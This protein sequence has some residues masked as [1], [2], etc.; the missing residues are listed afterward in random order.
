MSLP[1]LI[2]RGFIGIAAML[3]IAYLF[4]SNRKAIDWRLVGVG[5]GLQ[6]VFAVL[7]LYTDAGEAVFR[8]IGNGF[9]QVLSFTYDGSEFIFGPMGSPGGG[10]SFGNIFAFQV[11]PTIVF[12]ASLM[13]VLYHL[14]LV[15]PLVRGMGRFMAWAMRISGAESLGTAANVF[16]GQT[17]APL[18]VEPYVKSMTRS[19]LMTL[20]TGGMS[21]IAGGVL[22][23][24]ITF[25]G[26]DDPAARAQFAGHLLS[27]SIMSAPAAIVMAKILVPETEE[28]PTYGD[29]EMQVEKEESNVIEAAANGASEGLRLALNVGA[30]LLA[31]IALI[32][33]INYLL[34]VLG[35]PVTFGTEWYDLNALVERVTDGQFT[36]LS[37]EAIFGFV[38]APLA[39]AMGVESADVLRFG[40]LLGEKVAVNEFVAFASLG[41][42]EGVLSERSIIIGTYALCGFANFSSIAIQIGG[43]GGI[44]PSRRSEIAE[45]GLRAVLAGALASW[46]TASIAGML[47]G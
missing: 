42:L 13:G 2:L 40:T 37:L 18:V 24:Y 29:V 11:L 7:V 14:G 25:L 34:G 47:I 6:L 21:T 46:T 17:E 35:N 26:G 44:A 20:M 30:M 22:A 27:A 12:F 9:D 28:S 31:F 1:V 39:W 43:I 23:A 16:I 41:E 3:G 5:I 10:D 4:S 38:F 15:Q 33:M 36:S 32:A 8:A 19:E 45:L